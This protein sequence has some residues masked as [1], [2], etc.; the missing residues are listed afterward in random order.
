VV[1]VNRGDVDTLVHYLNKAPSATLAR[2]TDDHVVPPLLT[3]GAAE[4]PSTARTAFDPLFGNH[5]L[6]IQVH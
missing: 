4:D 5:T 2:P 6:S 1:R 3:L